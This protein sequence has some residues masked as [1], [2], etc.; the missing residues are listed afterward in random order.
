MQASLGE[1]SGRK[2]ESPTRLGAGGGSAGWGDTT[3]GAA[4]CSRRARMRVLPKEVSFPG[5][6]N[7]GLLPF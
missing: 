4:S 1:V 3:G 2:R 5:G 7:Y 6:R